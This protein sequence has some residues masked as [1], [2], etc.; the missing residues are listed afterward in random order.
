MINNDEIFD[1]FAGGRDLPK[2]RV[3]EDVSELGNLIVS[4]ELDRRMARLLA[5]HPELQVKFRNNNIANLDTETK[6]ALLQAMY[7]ALGIVP[8]SNE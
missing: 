4:S 2:H 1:G 8:L 5:L 3:R 6:E 7:D